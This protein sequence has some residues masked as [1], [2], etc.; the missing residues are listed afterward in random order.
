[1]LTMRSGAA[2]AP[3]ELGDPGLR[4]VEGGDDHGVDLARLQLGD[5]PDRRAEE[6]AA[7]SRAKTP[8]GS[9]PNSLSVR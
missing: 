7:G 9:K 1:M 3:C 4:P 2:P 6:Q 8:T 5:G